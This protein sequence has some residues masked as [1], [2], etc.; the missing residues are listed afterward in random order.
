MG[1]NMVLKLNIKIICAIIC[2]LIIFAV[3][4]PMLFNIGKTKMIVAGGVIHSAPHIENETLPVLNVEMD[5]LSERFH[6]PSKE[7]PSPNPYSFQDFYKENDDLSL[8]TEKFDNPEEV[9][10]AFYGILRDA[11]NMLGYSGGC[12]T[13][14]MSRLPYPYAYELLAVETQKEMPLKQFTA[15]FEGIGYITLLKILPAYSPPGTPKSTRYYMVEIEFITGYKAKNEED[16]KKGSLFAY[17][18]GLITV[19]QTPNNGWQ[20]RDIDYVVE[21]FLCAPLHGWFYMS[22]A[23]AEIVYVENLKLVDKIDKIEQEDN[24]VYVYAFGNGIS[25]RFDFV[26]ITNGYDILL[27]ENILVNGEWKETALLPDEWNYLKLTID[28]SMLKEAA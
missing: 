19:G 13:I 25:Y 5:R 28:N 10:L 9:I 12:G 23:I 22:D 24:M 14:G 15:S 11:S 27:H 1:D 4:L 3:C 20:I 6:R 16:Y 8:I 17:N 7:H 26:R 18:Y 2:V 21:D